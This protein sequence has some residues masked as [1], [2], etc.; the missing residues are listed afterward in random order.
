MFSVV[1]YQG[2]AA[3]D[4]QSEDEPRNVDALEASEVDIVHLPQKKITN[5]HIEKNARSRLV[6]CTCTCT[7][8]YTCMYIYIYVH[9]YIFSIDLT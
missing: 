1:W 2:A 3:E 9:I 8:A 7:P 5:I 4:C 6:K